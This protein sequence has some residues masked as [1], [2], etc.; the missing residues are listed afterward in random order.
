M[1]VSSAAAPTRFSHGEPRLNN[2]CHGDRVTIGASKL[3]FARRPKRP[4]LSQYDA[5]PIGNRQLSSPQRC[6]G[7]VLRSKPSVRRA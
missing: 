4:T 5:K 6:D 7:D 1:A 2:C 3:R